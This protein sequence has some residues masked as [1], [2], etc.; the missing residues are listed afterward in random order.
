MP[1]RPGW[2][3]S[4]P[5]ASKEDT[6]LATVKRTLR[7][8]RPILRPVWVRVKPVLEPSKKQKQ[9]ARP[10]VWR[11]PERTPSPDA[12]IH[13]L[14][15]AEFEAVAATAPTYYEGR[16]SYVSAAARMADDL[17]AR[18]DLRSALEL[19][20]H[21]RSLIVG[22]DVMDRAEAPDLQSEGR[23][24]VHDATVTPWPIAD[25]AYDLFVGLQVFEHLTGAQREAFL[26]VRRVARHAV[27][28]LPID[29]VMPDPANVHH[30]I[31]RETA[32]GWFAPVVP[33]HIEVGNTGPRTRLIYVFED[34]AP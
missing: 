2:T 32:L 12:P 21:L 1:P 10:N 15:E 5:H 31:S 7:P 18:H 33:T 22:A 6:I 3:S 9:P 23:V 28:S 27:I 30:Q 20:P 29:W 11:G 34:L 16:R 13:V 24:I 14:T 8:L 26:E 4:E 17:I 19:G 25:R